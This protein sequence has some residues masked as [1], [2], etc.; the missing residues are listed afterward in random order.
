ME[1]LKAGYCVWINPFNRTK[2]QYVSFSHCKVIV[3]W[4]KNP[5]PLLLYLSEI[6]SRGFE[7]YFQFTLND[8]VAEGLEPNVPSIEYRVETFIKLSEMIGKE[9]VIWRFDPI[10][11]GDGLTREVVLEKIFALG[12]KLS[13]YT[14]KLVFSFADIDA[15]TKV[16]NNLRQK[17]LSLREPSHDEMITF[18]K[19]IAAINSEFT[20]PLSL[21]SCAE[22][23][24]L[25][26]YGIQHNK[27]T[28]DNL[29]CRICKNDPT[30]LAFFRK[31]ERQ[32]SLLGEL[33]PV[34]SS[35]YFKDPGQR[36]ECGCVASKDIG[37]YGTCPHMCV[38]CYANPSEKNILMNMARL[39]PTSESLL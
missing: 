27:C 26:S 9:R 13:P 19:S 16:Q 21:A 5:A 12:K 24:D 35:T 39:Q 29:I 23:I 32:V 14:E 18:A 28:D 34:T 20:K 38:Y 30:V 8:Y 33:K 6:Q 15:Y 31:N 2:K 11:L 17:K 4:S 7:F 22:K 3:F 36:R 1:R 25:S 37:A 10:F